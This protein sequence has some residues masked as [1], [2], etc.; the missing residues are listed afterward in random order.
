VDEVH[1]GFTPRLA[2]IL[3]LALGAGAG[4]L[5]L[6]RSLPLG[7]PGEWVWPY[8]QQVEVTPAA[9]LLAAALACLILLALVW[10]K[11]RK[12][13]AKLALW[14]AGL[15]IVA[16]LV[17]LFAAFAAGRSLLY[18]GACVASPISTTYYAEAE[19]VPGFV[20]YIK[21]YRDSMPEL[22][23]HAATHPPGAVLIYYGL[24][25]FS[26]RLVLAASP[27]TFAYL[28]SHSAEVRL[29][30][31]A[32]AKG[33]GFMPSQLQLLAAAV[34]ALLFGLLS[35]LGVVFLY[36]LTRR[37]ADEDS[38][39]LAAL[40]YAVVPAWVVFL[41]SLDLLYPPVVLAICWLVVSAW[42][43]GSWPR[44]LIAGMLL[45]GLI[46]VN[47]GMLAVVVICALVF[48][49][50]WQRSKRTPEKRKAALKLAVTFAVGFV[51]PLVAWCAIGHVPE[52][53]VKAMAAH[54]AL[55]RTRTYPIWL[56]L[57]LVDAL[58][59]MGAATWPFLALAATRKWSKSYKLL[60]LF[61]S[62]VVIVLLL[63][64]LSGS[65]LGEVA[66]IWLFFEI[67]LLPPIAFLARERLGKY[68]LAL[69]AGLALQMLA[70]VFCLQVIKPF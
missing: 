46:F 3:T 34:T 61:A 26:Y 37:L 63:V 21:E 44:A 2:A 57:N 22:S 64:D 66:R 40:C 11:V 30:Q 68:L 50:L 13:K 45:A 58:F 69:P 65:V 67:A 41:P 25:Q 53:F 35:S 5:V 14:L 38:A 12:S 20:Q 7:L 32:L 15:V 39:A 31:E 49:G 27:V 55:T 59:F 42:Q 4:L 36:L 56:G 48:F 52:V 28:D 24:K 62:A 6:A 70:M 8:V 17:Q 43:T 18:L 33:A 29:W 60:G 54:R 10:R 9:W 51:V 19:K 23:Q 47:F 16:W 1:P